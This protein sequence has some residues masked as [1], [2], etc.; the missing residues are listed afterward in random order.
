VSL[1]RVDGAGAGGE[2]AVVKRLKL[3]ADADADLLAQ[4]ADEVRVSQR[5]THPNI[6]QTLAT[7]EG[8]EGPFLVFEYL[9]GQKLARTRGRASRRAG[10]LPRPI[11]LH[12][13]MAVANGLAYAHAAKDENG[14]RLRILHRDVSPENIILTYGG[15]TK[16]ID[17]SVATATTAPKKGSS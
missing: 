9:E 13:I 6:A 7:G 4:F 3:G 5:L 11:A 12:I 2:L 16:L 1:A 10:G 15:E 8:A 14:K 17:F